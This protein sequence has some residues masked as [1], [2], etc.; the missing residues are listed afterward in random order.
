MWSTQFLG[1]TGEMFI[2]KFGN[3]LIWSRIRI[4]KAEIETELIPIKELTPVIVNI[5]QYQLL[6]IV[7]INYL[8]SETKYDLPSFPQSFT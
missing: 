3:L 4:L 8:A 5:S 1:Q 6:I 2:K 7:N